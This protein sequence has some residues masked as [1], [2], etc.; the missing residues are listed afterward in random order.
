MKNGPW[1]VPLRCLQPNEVENLLV[2]CRG[3][4]FSS[5]AASACR[6][7]RTMKEMGEAAGRFAAT[8]KVV[9][10]DQPRTHT[11]GYLMTSRR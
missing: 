7:Q 9:A 1:G 10:R 8:G 11:E 2:A 5:L 4:S 3:A 6:L